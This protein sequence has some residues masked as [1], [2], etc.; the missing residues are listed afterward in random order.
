MRREIEDAWKFRDNETL[1]ERKRA[2]RNIEVVRTPA[3]QMFIKLYGPNCGI[4]W[5]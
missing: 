3:A 1:G 4:M 2:E 5:P